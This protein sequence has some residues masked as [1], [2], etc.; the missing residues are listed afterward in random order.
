MR[1]LFVLLLALVLDLLLGEPPRAI[2]PVVWMGKVISFLKKFAP[3]S[4]KSSSSTGG[5]RK[6]QL[7]YGGVMV[8]F[9][10]CIFAAPVY[11][12]LLYISQVSSIAYIIGGA[13]VLKSAF[14][15]RQLRHA[16]LEIKGLLAKDNLKDARDMMPALV[17]RETHGLG[18]TALAS[19]AVES[20]AENI[21][22]SFVAPLFYFLF[23]GVPGAVAY[24]VINTCDAMIGYH[25]EYEYLGKFAAKLDDAL[26]FIPARIS[27]L[28]LVIAAYLSK[29]NGRNA[30]RVM[31]LEHGKTESPNAGWPMAAMAGA[32][33]VRLEKAGSYS[34][35]DVTNPLT[36]SL[37]IS[38]VKLTD[39][40]AL[41][42]VLVC[43]IMEVAYFAFAT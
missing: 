21:S 18:K 7:I 35:G 10:V 16:V 42:W 29:E 30:W 15:F 3:G 24:R 23:L 9:T 6:R 28:L 25:G 8:L 26:N 19:A 4:S 32:L 17:S 40:A 11:F 31:L 22:D 5:G 37:I 20:V 13:V 38:G 43:L 39:V 1:L 2:H 41:L 27:G 12:I 36:P 33:R 14:A 34:L